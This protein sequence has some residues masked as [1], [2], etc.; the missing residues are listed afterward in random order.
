LVADELANEVF[1][2]LDSLDFELLESLFNSVSV[3]NLK[4]RVGRELE[5]LLQLDVLVLG[6]Q[7]L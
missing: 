4:D 7:D 5:E 3:V 2:N 6:A 1:R